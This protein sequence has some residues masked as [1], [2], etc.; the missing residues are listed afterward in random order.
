MGQLYDAICSNISECDENH[1]YVISGTNV[2][3][4]L[5]HMKKGKNDGLT[6]D[7]LLNGPPLLFHC[8]S[9]LFTAMLKHSYAPKR[10][11]ISTVIPIP[12][13]MNKNTAGYIALSSL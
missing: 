2:V 11:C 13:G 5:K 12:K 6:S 7:Y 9:V 1:S 3:D 10:F 8:L 4:D